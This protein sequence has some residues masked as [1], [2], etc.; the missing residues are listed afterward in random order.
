L[1][2]LHELLAVE[3]DLEGTW[4]KIL[5]E[6]AATLTKR[7]TLFSGFV[8]KLVMFEESRQN[9]ND[10]EHKAMST[11][12]FEKLDY[13][14]KSCVKYFDAIAQ[15]EATNQVARADL[16]VDNI[17]IISDMPATLLLGLE[18]RLKH[19]R[20]IYASIPT[21][22]PSIEWEKDE[23]MGAGVYRSVHTEDAFKTEKTFRA[24][25]LYE[26]KFPKDGEGG[27]SL[28]AQIEK[29]SETENI[30][31]YERTT[32]TGVLSS[33]DK[34]ILLKRLDKLI[35]GV[36]QARQRANSAKVVPLD[37]GKKLFDYVHKV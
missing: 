14:W 30:G 31:K 12:V 32:W 17:T 29:I 26:A 1:A 13:M 8:R 27:A 5:V 23:S 34:S 22:P 24:K 11:T 37:I 15:K 35:R 10:E 6:T 28:P 7:Q 2:K 9:E 25:V 4:K 21:L 3:G 19:V 18:S 20:D 33:A 16:I 36:K